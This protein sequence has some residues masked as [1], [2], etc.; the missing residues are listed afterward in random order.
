MMN[1]IDANEKW[2]YR[3]GGC[4][5]LVLGAAYVIIIPLYARVGAPPSDGEAWLNYL[6]G[7]T[8]V[9]WAILGLSV[10]TDLLFVPVALSLYSALKEV[11]R[12][13]MLLATALIALFVVLDLAV[14]WSNFAALLTLGVRYAAAS[15]A[16][17]AAYAGAANYAAAVLASRLEIVYAIVILSSGILIVGVVMMKDIFNKLTAYL[18]VITGILGIGAMTRVTAIIIANAICAT[19]WMLLVGYRLVRLGQLASLPSQAK[20]I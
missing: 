19:V 17:R 15:N 9:W 6:Q 7:K 1:G 13:A 12:N 11:N 4:S 2:L 18:A 5:A 8:P 3:V 20:S 14:T 16:A 10:F